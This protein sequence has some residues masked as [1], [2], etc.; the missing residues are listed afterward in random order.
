MST[1]CAYNLEELEN[2]FVSKCEI[3]LGLFYLAAEKIC[4][5]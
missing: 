1:E 3:K 2:P 4:V 5:S